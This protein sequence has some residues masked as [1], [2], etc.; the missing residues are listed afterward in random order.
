MDFRILNTNFAPIGLLDKYESIIWNVRFKEA[1][2]FELYTPVAN[3]L[4]D[5]LKIGNY[6]FCDEFYN[7]STNRAILMIIET[8]EITT[9]SENGDT[10]K[11]TGRDLKSILDRRIIWGQKTFK[12]N[13]SI[14]TII[15]TILNENIINPQDWSKTYQDGDGGSRTVSI[16]GSKRKI[17]NFVYESIG[18]TFPSIEKDVEYN[19]NNIYDTVLEICDAFNIGF[20][21]LFDFNSNRFVF[22]LKNTRNRTTSSSNP[23][24]FSPGFENLKNSSY[25]ESSV[26]EKNS[27][28]ISGSG[29]EYNIMYNTIG[30][31]LS[32]LYRREMHINPSDVTV[33]GDE[34]EIGD[35]HGNGTYLDMLYS[36]ALEEL[37]KNEYTQK[38]SGEAETLQGYKYMTDYDLGDI[39]EIINEW[40]IGAQVIITEVVSSI[41]TSNIST[42]PTF[43]SLEEGG[44]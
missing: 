44:D 4:I 41:S 11:V 43:T 7:Q 34:D 22:R 38:Y 35:V 14:D 8:I 29:D 20:E 9:D 32:G 39:C 24:V 27:A 3:H 13:T 5:I 23:L 6:L 19:C 21:V 18:Y 15:Q 16:Q 10:L 40:G 26:T 30:N 36:K 28:L 2:E 42:I 17:N 12:A 25:I 31:D 37:S 33:A 1:G